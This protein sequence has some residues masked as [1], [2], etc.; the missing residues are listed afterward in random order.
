[1]RWR[2][3]VAA[4]VAISC[5][6]RLPPIEYSPTA[7]HGPRVLVMSGQAEDVEELQLRLWRLGFEVVKD[8]E[9]R[10]RVRFVVDR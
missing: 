4:F 7:M 2:V 3:L 6:P 1:M 5:A 8:D 10:A 9:P